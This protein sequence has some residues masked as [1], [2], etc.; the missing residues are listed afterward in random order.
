MNLGGRRGRRRLHVAL[1]ALVLAPLTVLGGCRE[2]RDPMPVLVQISGDSEMTVSF[3][4]CVGDDLEDVSIVDVDIEGR[5]VLSYSEGPASGAPS[6]VISLTVTPATL[7][8]ADVSDQLV[9]GSENRS[10][11]LLESLRP[12]TWFYVD[13]ER[14]EASFEFS[15]LLSQPPGWYVVSGGEST[16]PRRTVEQVGSAEKGLGYI[17]SWCG[18]PSTRPR[19]PT[20][21]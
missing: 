9:P 15:A 19:F 20:V 2:V 21:P 1:V 18:G 17:R 5:P 14:F 4:V 8:Q 11:P 7:A 6:D 10:F 13:T 12:T 3:M 16:E